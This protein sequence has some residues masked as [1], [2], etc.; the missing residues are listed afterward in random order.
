MTK[1]NSGQGRL[2][3]GARHIVVVTAV[4][5]TATSIALAGAGSSF[6]LWNSSVVVSAGSV[7]SGAVAVTQ[8]GFAAMGTQFSS[9]NLSVT[10]PVTVTNTGSVSSDFSA[11][12]GLAAG[13]SPALASAVSV[14]VWEIGSD[15][16]CTV[17]SAPLDPV[18]GTW[19]APPALTGR[20]APGTSQLL[21]FRSILEPGA[22]MSQPGASV[23]PE[24]TVTA[25]VGGWSALAIASTTQRTPSLP[26]IG[27]TQQGTTAVLD[28]PNPGSSNYGLYLNGVAIAKT[29]NATPPY[30]FG[31]DLLTAAGIVSPG[32]VTVEVRQLGQ[33]TVLF[34]RTVTVVLVGAQLELRC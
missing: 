5:A 29:K 27:C 10:A 19:S 13:S 15:A 12:L 9:D 16:E 3:S 32:V 26:G 11:S 6:A 21:C 33:A 31:A 24:L 22:L 7:T 20:L 14:S 8:Q 1:S 4:L 18:S 25:R 23:T 28:W 34:I 2:R 30:V 17:L